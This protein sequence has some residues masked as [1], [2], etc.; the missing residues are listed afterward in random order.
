MKTAP[1]NRV[2]W[3][4][5]GNLG[6]LILEV[7]WGKVEIMQNSNSTFSRK[8]ETIRKSKIKMLEIK[9]TKNRN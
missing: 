7:L 3:P 8:K 6:N 2:I 4:R 5:L 1:H 9:N